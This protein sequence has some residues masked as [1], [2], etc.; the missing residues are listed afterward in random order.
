MEGHKKI[1]A[2]FTL[3]ELMISIAL[4]FIMAGVAT[5]RIMAWLPDYRLKAAASDLKAN[6]Q[7][8]RLRAVN[9]NTTVRIQFNRDVT[10][11]FYYFDDDQDGVWDADEFRV[12]LLSYHS[13]VDFGTGNAAAM[14]N[15]NA[16]AGPTAFISFGSRGTSNALTVYLQN[17][18]ADKCYAVTTTVAGTAK[19]RFYNG[20]LPFN[21]NNWRE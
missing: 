21:T 10:P 2:G 19:V 13:G 18:N 3:I 7:R 16:F 8:A 4:I 20:S 9:E 17:Q 15:G 1:P 11:G 12:D 14:W 5:P 6:M